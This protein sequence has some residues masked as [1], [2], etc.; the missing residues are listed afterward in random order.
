MKLAIDLSSLLWP[1]FKSKME[2]SV[3]S[4]ILYSYNDLLKRFR[5]SEVAIA[6]D[7]DQ[8]IR[9][10]RFPAYKA[11]RPPKPE[12]L[13]EQ[14]VLAVR[15][16]AKEC[17]VGRKQG[18]EADDVLAQ[19]ALDEWHR[20]DEVVLV[21]SDKDLTQLVNDKV[22]VWS[23]YHRFLIG[24]KNVHDRWGIWPYELPDFLAIAGDRADGIP[25]LTGAGIVK[26]REL[27]RVHGSVEGALSAK[28][29]D[30][31]HTEELRLYRWLVKLM[32]ELPR[33]K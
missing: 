15:T 32:P 4:R 27:I 3:L 12:G 2:G 19:W 30:A 7:D 28:A 5:P 18:W 16:L 33:K 11:N 6:V 21:S 24:P 9:R 8:S 17:R 14:K 25:G 13:E 29:I 1:A 20:E 10:Q 26:A 31:K 23:P 22:K